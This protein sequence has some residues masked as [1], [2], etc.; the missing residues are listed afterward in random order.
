[1]QVGRRGAPP[2]FDAGCEPIGS[3]PKPFR[4]LSTLPL[5]M[6]HPVT[7]SIILEAFEDLQRTVNEFKAANDDRL[8]A[9]EKRGADPAES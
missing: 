4:Q 7:E 5:C 6:E 9:I 3:W 1:M 8:A 2:R